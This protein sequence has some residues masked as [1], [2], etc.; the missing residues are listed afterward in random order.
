MQLS[1]NHHESG[2]QQA[3]RI[4]K[5]V[6]LRLKLLR[7]PAHAGIAGLSVRDFKP[8]GLQA[9]G[10]LVSGKATICRFFLSPKYEEW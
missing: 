8:T 3:L 7:K 5:I 4:R 1:N 6:I 9:G 2:L 10:C